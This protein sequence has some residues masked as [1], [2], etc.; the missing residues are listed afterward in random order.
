MQIAC[1]GSREIPPESAN[2]CREMGMG[3]VRA[4]YTVVTGAT[5]GTPG[6]DDWANWA[7]AAFAAGAYYLNPTRLIVCLPWQHF[8]HG[9]G[10]PPPEI[11]VGYVEEHLEWAEAARRY[12]EAERAAYVGPWAAIHRATS[13][14][15]VRNAGIILQSRL[16]LAWPHG[17]ANGTR[18]AMGF[19][20][21]RGVP[22]IDLEI[23]P[24]REALAALVAQPHL[25][26]DSNRC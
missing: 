22:V 25:I 11:S 19:A 9:S 10:S 24:W 6:R 2:A 18:F 7:D 1:I 26:G 23:A 13:L 15:Y 8:P 20:E 16:V 17:E 14:R 21:W 5:P 4:G 12:W 3:L